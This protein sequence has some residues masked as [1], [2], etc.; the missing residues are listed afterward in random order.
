MADTDT[1]TPSPD[2]QWIALTVL[3]GAFVGLLGLATLIIILCWKGKECTQAKDLFTALLPVFATWVG[4]LLAFYFSK[5]NFESATK[6]V[7]EMANKIS[8]ADEKLKARS[9]E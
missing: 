3:I 9:E 1:E 7:T 8:G 4:T 5:D 6:S 2:R